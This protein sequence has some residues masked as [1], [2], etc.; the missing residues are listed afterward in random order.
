MT[1]AQPC[2]S[3]N[4]F[5]I[6]LKGNGGHGARPHYSVDTILMAAQII[7]GFQFVANRNIDP[8]EP[9]VLSACTING[10]T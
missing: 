8:T 1:G 2:A 3:T 4:P 6:T 5:Y 7:S 9:I 10:G